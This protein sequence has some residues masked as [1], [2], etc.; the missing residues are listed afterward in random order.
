MSTQLLVL[1][2][3]APDEK[4]L[5]KADYVLNNEIGTMKFTRPAITAVESKLS[6]CAAHSA[7]F[8]K[9]WDNTS[10]DALKFYETQNER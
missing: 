8:P 6:G 5:Q 10:E 9:Y 3:E 4:L 1:M 7:V 2:L